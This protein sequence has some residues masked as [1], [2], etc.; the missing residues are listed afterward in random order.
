MRMPPALTFM[1]ALKFSCAPSSRLPL[2]LLVMV[3]AVAPTMPRRRSPRCSGDTSVAPFTSI[4]PTLMVFVP[5]KFTRPS[6]RAML[7]TSCEVETMP[8]LPMVSVP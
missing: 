5:P 2:P 6:M 7:C 4:V 3:P 8:E 1:P